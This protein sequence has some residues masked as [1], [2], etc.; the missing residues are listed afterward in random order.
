M[1]TEGQNP[2]QAPKTAPDGD[3]LKTRSGMR[4]WLKALLAVSLAANLAVAGLAVGAAVRWRDGDHPGRR[5]PSVGAMIF[6]DLDRDTRRALHNRAEGE[7]GSHIAR[8][9]A[10]G[11]AVI[12]ILMGDPFQ[13]EALATL[14][15]QQAE[16]RHAFYIS[17]QEAWVAQLE[18]MAAEDRKRYAQKMQERFKRHGDD[19][20]PRPPGH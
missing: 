17:V 10:E 12:A 2:D 15:R 9:R 13:A 5:P 6:R 1:T 20:P 11:D 4:P 19:G 14:L 3:E 8:R 16:S 18:A 7:H